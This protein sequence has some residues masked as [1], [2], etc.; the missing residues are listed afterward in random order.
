[1]SSNLFK[2]LLSIYS[3]FIN[4]DYILGK[5]INHRIVTITKKNTPLCEFN[6][7]FGSRSHQVANRIWFGGKWD[8]LPPSYE[9][10]WVVMFSVCSHPGVGGFRGTPSPSHN[11][12]TGPMTFPGGTPV[13]GSRSPTRGY[14]SPRWGA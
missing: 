11:T 2:P 8:L 1:M 4:F 10:R 7:S 12:S 14:P 3:V 6:K 13:T 9:V 5:V